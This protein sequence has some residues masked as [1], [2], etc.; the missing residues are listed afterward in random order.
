MPY[1]RKTPSVVLILACLLLFGGCDA[2][3]TDDLPDSQAI[4]ERL[5]EDWEELSDAVV[6][7]LEDGFTALEDM[8]DEAGVPD[9][10]TPAPANRDEASEAERRA[11]MR[12][13]E[14]TIVEET[15][16]RRAEHGLPPL[17][18]SEALSEIARAHSRDM[19]HRSFYAHDNPDELGPHDRIEADL[20]SSYQLQMS[21]ENIAHRHLP[22]SGSESAG[23]SLGERLVEMWMGSPGHR[24]NILRERLTHIGV[25]LYP[26]S[27]SIY[28]TQK[29]ITDRQSNS[30]GR[31]G[32]LG[33][34]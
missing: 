6:G 5:A 29:F 12:I 21:A 19:V 15:N 18:H 30:N 2:E 26:G 17:E 4:Q 34:Q 16:A 1:L 9:A 33:V 3:D 31:G 11:Q 8:L 7:T 25:G 23:H 28:A 32:G 14:E 13:A 27:T 20:P 24:E 22:L 10:T